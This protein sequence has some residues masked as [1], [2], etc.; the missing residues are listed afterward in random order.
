MRALFFSLVLLLP[1]WVV[2]QSSKPVASLAPKGQKYTNTE[3]KIEWTLLDDKSWS[4]KKEPQPGVL[5]VIMNKEEQGG[6]HPSVM[7]SFDKLPKEVSTVKDYAEINIAALSKY[8]FTDIKQSEAMFNG[9]S[10]IEV[11]AYTEGGKKAAN[12]LYL[13]KNGTGYVLTITC[14]SSMYERYQKQ[15]KLARATLTFTE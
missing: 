14:P 10:A 5:A 12:Q 6:S 3:H 15:L 11:E 7:L 4:L 8:G 1:L 13:I 2:G 9:L